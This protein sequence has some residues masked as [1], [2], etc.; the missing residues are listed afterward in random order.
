MGTLKGEAL[1]AT[2]GLTTVLQPGPVKL[3]PQL[4]EKADG[5]E[6]EIEKRLR[7]FV[8]EP[9]FIEAPDPEPF[10]FE[11]IVRL[12][13]GAEQ[14]SRSIENL[15]GFQDQELANEFGDA[16]GGALG[17]VQTLLP[18]E[19]LP[20]MIGSKDMKPSDLDV[21]EFRRRYDV[22]NSPL[23]VFDDMLA[24]PLVPDQVEA[25]ATVYP[26]LYERAKAILFHELAAAGGKGDDWQ[27]PYDK[28]QVMQ[29][30]LQTDTMTPD[31][32]AELTKTFE[33][34]RERESGQDAAGRPSKPSRKGI[35]DPS[36]MQERLEAK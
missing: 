17:Y 8:T 1:C 5:I 33:A 26:A 2:V 20:A 22:C 15:S 29:L 35:G 21:S 16:L 30:F 11:E 19:T 31:L 27:L 3:T 36:T 25:F 24:G 10:G 13:P 32:H 12:L 6:F 34:A 28:D 23:V 9:K 14:E 18:A 4:L 7:R